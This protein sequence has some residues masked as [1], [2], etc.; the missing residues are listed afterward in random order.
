MSLEAFIKDRKKLLLLAEMDLENFSYLV[1]IQRRCNVTS[2]TE[3]ENEKA[4]LQ[5]IHNQIKNLKEYIEEPNW[6]KREQKNGK[7]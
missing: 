7:A 4:A 6:I 1:V 5:L 2:R 3:E